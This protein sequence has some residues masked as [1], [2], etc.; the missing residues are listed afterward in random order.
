MKF[1]HLHL[2][3]DH[4]ILDGCCKNIDYI[5]KA[6]AI[7]M[8]SI[9][10][11]NHGT[12]SGTLE[13][14]N[15]CKEN[16]I[17]PILGV[18]VYY[19]ASNIR[20]NR[21]LT[22]SEKSDK[23]TYG[24]SHGVLLAKNQKGWENIMAINDEAYREGYYYRPRT[25]KK[26]IQEHSEGIIFSTACLGGEISK[27]I[28]NNMFE[29]AEKAFCEWHKL[30][31][32][33]F[34]AE[35]QMNEIEEQKKV[36]LKMIEMSNK[37]GV[38]MI[39]T[40]DVHYLNNGD[41]LIQDVMICVSQKKNFYD[42]DRWHYP[43]KTVFFCEPEDFFKFNTSHGYHYSEEFITEGIKNT[44]EIA[45]KCNFDFDF[46]TN[47]YPEYQGLEK[48]DVLAREGLRD[49][50]LSGKENYQKRLELELE[51]IDEMGFND[52][53]LVIWDIINYSRNNDVM[54][55]CG[56]GSVC[57]SLVAYALRITTIDPIYHGLFFERFI[58]ISRF[59]P[60]DIDLDF[61]SEKGDE[62]KNYIKSTYGDDRVLSVITFSRFSFKSVFRD[63]MRV[64]S[65]DTQYYRQI[66][67]ITKSWDKDLSI[68]ENV[69]LLLPEI[70]EI[71]EL[72]SEIALCR[73]LSG[74]I[75]N[76]GKHAGGVV[77]TPGVSSKYL[78]LNKVS[79][80]LV[81]AYAES[82]NYTECSKIGVLKI[83][84]LKIEGLT[85]INRVM[86]LIEKRYNKV[87]NL[88]SDIDYDDPKLMEDFCNR[89]VAGVFQF[90][91]PTQ[92]EYVGKFLP[93]KFSDLVIQ[94]AILRPATMQ[95]G[96][97]TELIY[98]KNFKKD[99]GVPEVIKPYL[100]EA[101]GTFVY[102]E[103]L[104]QIL[105]EVM[106]VSLNE[107][108]LYRSVMKKAQHGKTEKFDKLLKEFS[109]KAISKGMTKLEVENLMGKL[110]DFASYSFNKSHSVAYTKMAVQMMWLKHYYS[111]EY[112]AVLLSYADKKEYQHY[113]STARNDHNIDFCNVDINES[114]EE[115]SISGDKIRVGFGLIDQ[116][117]AKAVNSIKKKRPYKSFEDFCV[118][119]PTDSRVSDNL[120]MAGA[121]DGFYKNRVKLLEWYRANH[122]NVSVGQL[123]FLES[124]EF[125][126]SEVD[127]VDCMKL[128]KEMFG[129][130]LLYN[131]FSIN[132]RTQKIKRVQKYVKPLNK[133]K[134]GLTVCY[135]KDVK[136]HKQKNGQTMAICEIEDYEGYEG[137]LL[138]FASYYS[139][140]RKLVVN[141]SL[142]VVEMYLSDDVFL[143][144]Q[145]GAYKPTKE[146]VTRDFLLNL[147]VF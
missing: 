86:K 87:V 91:T 42:P 104:L 81:T 143:F 147:D 144:G 128:E 100:N 12:L 66:N 111:L 33:D 40:N 110:K 4:S 131:P 55:G 3:D 114:E 11:T 63:V 120:I 139:M 113:M 107:A 135:F 75:R 74:M 50:G 1:T 141:G 49:L 23:L 39:L 2:H 29:E 76:K 125:V 95:N 118:K 52:Y 65:K 71:R 25:T 105:S 77:I 36:N 99:P 67:A 20:V 78:P 61:D 85:I 21:K 37:Y 5:K 83:D 7:G 38:K 46:K 132:G 129:F 57:G 133:L 109:V 44:Q 115:F 13:F 82:G 145:L 30:F 89:K 19:I 140:I 119:K 123:S 73:R 70:P 84:V 146:I 92:R 88:E 35:I 138:I 79:G 96:E 26:F 10:I 51:V 121:F 45:D 8:E 24:Y 43:T 68:T 101:Y 116:I 14:Y 28:S 137:R 122:D 9:A 27:L 54:V 22:D 130:N 15:L 102:Q 124:V 31:G 47:H 134:A 142:W 6:K 93:K 56:R 98:R 17:K 16:D 41:D 97:S 58:N 69:D 64:M 60:P 112:Y 106:G 32:D 136:P 72:K 90:D 117:G 53:F 18:E 126:D 80:E 108:D 62:V 48:I 59:E 94:N 127:E 103:H 34:Y